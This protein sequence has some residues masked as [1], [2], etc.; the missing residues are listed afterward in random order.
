MP[1]IPSTFH[2]FRIRDGAGTV[3]RIRTHHEGRW[4]CGPLTWTAAVFNRRVG[5]GNIMFLQLSHMVVHAAIQE[6]WDD[7]EHH[8]DLVEQLVSER[9]NTISWHI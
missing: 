5:G 1:P 9:T 6:R 8:N 2:V 7:L 3:L 4:R